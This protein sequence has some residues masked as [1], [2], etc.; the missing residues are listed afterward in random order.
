MPVNINTVNKLCNEN[1]KNEKDMLNWLE[2][3]QLVYDKINNSEEMAKKLV[4]N[5]IKNYFIIIL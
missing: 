1:I 3:N 5:Y 4:K 2:K